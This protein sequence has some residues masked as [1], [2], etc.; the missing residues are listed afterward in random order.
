MK[1]LDGLVRRTVRFNRLST[2]SWFTGYEA[3]RTLFQHFSLAVLP[4][5]TIRDRQILKAPGHIGVAGIDILFGNRQGLPGAPHSV[6]VLAC[7]VENF[8]LWV[9]GLPLNARS[10]R[11][12]DRGLHERAGARQG[13]ATIPAYFIVE[14]AHTANVRL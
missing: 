14:T 13:K 8:G 1:Q 4:C 5:R 6:V 12:H 3:Y 7:L 9:R 11:M 2:A 10:L